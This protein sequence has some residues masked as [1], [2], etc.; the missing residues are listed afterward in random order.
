MLSRRCYNSRKNENTQTFK[1]EVFFGN[2]LERW[3]TITIARYS[4]FWCLLQYPFIIFCSQDI[5]VSFPD[6]SNLFSRVWFQTTIF[7]SGKITQVTG[8]KREHID[9]HFSYMKRSKIFRLVIPEKYKARE[10]LTTDGYILDKMKN[11]VKMVFL[12]TPVYYFYPH[13]MHPKPD[14]DILQAKLATE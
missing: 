12:T 8:S 7:I 14:S 2:M 9:L 11:G 10:K 6:S 13:R 1:F 3:Y 4:L 5:L